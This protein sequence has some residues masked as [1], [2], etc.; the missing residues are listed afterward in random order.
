MKMFDELKDLVKK[1]AVKFGKFTLASGRESDIYVDM[2]KVTLNPKG[3]F[4]IG[5]LIYEMIK[6][7]GVEA[8]GGLTM[9]ADPIATASSLVAYQKGMELSA[10]LVRKEK[11]DHGMK[12][13]VEGP[14]QPG[15]KVVVVDDVIT[16]GGSTITAIEN[17]RAMGLEV[18]MVIAVFDR[19]EGGRANIEAL[20]P[21]VRA[22]LTRDDL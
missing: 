3:A 9:G 18:V 19:L 4:L 8:I 2:R 21:D 22:L 16:T 7:S 15:Q 6:D 20:V 14:V 5:S 1:D 13:A 11:K 10:F 17:A 12:N